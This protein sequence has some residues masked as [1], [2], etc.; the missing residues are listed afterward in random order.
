MDQEV[1]TL[2]EP[3]KARDVVNV[4]DRVLLNAPM[5]NGD[6]DLGERHVSEVDLMREVLR[7]NPVNLQV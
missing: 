1:L 7:C 5:T 6:P 3:R 4:K 2:S